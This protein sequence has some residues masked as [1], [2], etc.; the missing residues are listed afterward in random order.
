MKV[1]KLYFVDEETDETRQEMFEGIQILAEEELRTVCQEYV[2]DETILPHTFESWK[3]DNGFDVVD[4]TTLPVHYIID[5]LRSD[6]YSV[7]S[8]E[9]P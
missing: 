1:Y 8:V 5:L 7:E 2:E 3:A 6:G 4:F 9:L